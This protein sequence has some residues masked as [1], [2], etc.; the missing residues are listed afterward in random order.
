LSGDE[1]I[2]QTNRLLGFGAMTQKENFMPKTTFTVKK[3]ELS[4]VMDRIF[5]ATPEQIFKVISDPKLIPNWWGP[6]RFTT[7][8]D[9]MDFR[10]GGQW[11][12][13]HKGQDGQEFS[14]HGVYKEI[15]P[16]QKVS[17]TF[18][19][20]GVPGDHE[21]VETMILEA[22]ESGSKTKMTTMSVFK[23]IQDLEGMV[24]S[25]MESGAVEAWE[26]LA[27]LVEKA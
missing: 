16:N 20:E 5:N 10:V 2:P 25:G 1:A 24:G 17:D 18:N 6:K 13:I 4:V 7:I 14:F 9:K 23:N 12:Y 11:R 19:Y 22:L 21:I 27:E 15:I 3:Q 26:R 8:V